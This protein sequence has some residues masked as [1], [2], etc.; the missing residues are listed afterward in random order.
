MAATETATATTGTATVSPASATFTP[1]QI[2]N[3]TIYKLT[4]Y[5][6]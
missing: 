3:T 5:T 2:G 1:Q 6:G 4:G